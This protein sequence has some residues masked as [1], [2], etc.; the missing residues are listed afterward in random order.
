MSRTNST[1]RGGAEAQRNTALLRVS[2][3]PRQIFLGLALS[4]ALHAQV[5]TEANSG[6]KTPEGRQSVAKG[7]ADPARDQRQKPQELVAAMA[8]SAA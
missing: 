6:Y 3:S 1:R 4:L 5:A 8:S 7:L 2:A